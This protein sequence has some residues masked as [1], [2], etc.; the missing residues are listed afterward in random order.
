MTKGM[1]IGLQYVAGNSQFMF[2]IK[3]SMVQSFWKTFLMEG[4]EKQIWTIG[5]STRTFDEFLAMLQA[6][7]IQT[8]VDVRHFPGPR[9]FPQYNK[10]VLEGELRT[11][12]IGYKHIIEL[13]GRRK[14]NKDSKNTVW[15]HPAFRAY[16]DYMQTEEFCIG[17]D[18]LTEIASRGQIAYM[19]SEAV[20]W[21]C[22]RSLISDLLKF[23]GWHVKHIMAV[24]K[25]EKHPY[26]RAANLSK[27]RL[28]YE[29]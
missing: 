3:C 13:G 12:N 4:T 27:G 2:S 1:G 16:A 29:P 10:E 23:N 9:K 18:I 28:S 11:N 24:G 19:C 17:I 26:T 25:A 8:V 6:F 7:G 22:H 15:R 5:H 14:L 21:R 20:W